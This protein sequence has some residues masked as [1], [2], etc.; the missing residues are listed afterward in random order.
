MK[1]IYYGLE[2]NVQLFKNEEEKKKKK[3]RN[4]DAYLSNELFWNNAQ[5]VLMEKVN[6]S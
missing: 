6:G 2:I 1:L 3:E 4:N 5:N